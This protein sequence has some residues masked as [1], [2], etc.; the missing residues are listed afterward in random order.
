MTRLKHALAAAD[1]SVVTIAYSNA[2]ISKEALHC[3]TQ[4]LNINCLFTTD[5]PVV[6]S[7][8]R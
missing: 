1:G 7:Q 8:D 6:K 4:V 5:G 3:Y 2:P